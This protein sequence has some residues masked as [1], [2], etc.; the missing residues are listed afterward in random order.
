MHLTFKDKKVIYSYGFTLILYE[1][2]AQNL[3][4]KLQPTLR[5]N[6]RMLV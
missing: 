1:M 2:F 4:M 3:C 6:I 5:T